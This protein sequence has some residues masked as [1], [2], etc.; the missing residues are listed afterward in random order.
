MSPPWLSI[1][2]PVYRVA[3]YLDACLA[4]I[5][6]QDVEGVEVVV[7]DDASPDGEAA[8]LV[9]WQA[10]HP[11][12]MRVVTHPANRGIAVTR[13]TLLDQARGDYLWFVDSD[14]LMAPGSIA[15]LREVLAKQRTDIVLCDFRIIRESDGNADESPRSRS[16][17]CARDAH[18][19]T[20]DGR[21]DVVS[22][23]RDHLIRGLFGPGHLHAWSKIVRRAAWPP[24]LRFA[25]NRAFEDLALMPRVALSMRSFIHVPQAWVSYRQRPGS[26]LSE[27]SS[28]KLDDWMAASAGY[29]AHLRD[30]DAGISPAT[31][32]AFAHF[33]T[34]EWRDCVRIF[35]R[36]PGSADPRQTLARF[37][38]HWKA[39]SPLSVFG[40]TWAYLRRGQVRRC[41]EMHALLRSSGR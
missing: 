7:V 25:Q 2:V 38:A 29:G 12:R 13:N 1:L 18:V 26:I 36:L 33:C 15:A 30:S 41:L 23:N 27:P 34:R 5:L 37:R 40:L 11:G 3:P 4:S 20:F 24:E 19:C 14:D 16:R 17:Q 32:F 39:A 8:M 10:R 28:D 6:E 22:R 9:A 35:H 21:A 31:L